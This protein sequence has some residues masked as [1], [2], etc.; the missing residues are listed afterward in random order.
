MNLKEERLKR[1]QKKHEEGEARQALDEEFWM[2]ERDFEDLNRR[3][4]VD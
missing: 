3:T 2:I 1:K 4:R